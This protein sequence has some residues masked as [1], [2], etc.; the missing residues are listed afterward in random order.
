MYMK[1]KDVLLL[2]VKISLIAQIF[3]FVIQLRGFFIK[4]DPRD[5]V[6]RDVLIMETIV[7][8]IEGAWYVWIAYA[9]KGLKNDTIA[10]R[11][12]MDWV[13]TTPVMLIQ[14]V[15]LMAFFTYNKD[16]F[17][18]KTKNEE[19]K[20]IL[21]T[22]DFMKKNQDSLIKIVVFNFIMLGFGYLAETKLLNKLVAIPAGFLFFFLSFR[23]IWEK[24]AYK[25]VKGRNLFY[26][27]AGIWSLYGVAAGLDVITK[28]VM[29]NILDIIS[30]NFYGLYV[31]YEI[32]NVTQ[33][34]K[35]IKKRVSKSDKLTK[36]SLPKINYFESLLS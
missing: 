16:M 11:R 30:K 7:Q 26:G 17:V 25:T 35:K 6:L 9:L 23:E 20:P 13:I 3:A 4:L 34:R 18:G 5:I 28:N 2:T 12:Y 31:L 21:T 36:E 15:L 29:Y 24:F 10:G 8:L 32:L 27:M 14:T 19:E 1:G 22:V 33:K